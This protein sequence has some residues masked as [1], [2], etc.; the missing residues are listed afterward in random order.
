MA[1]PTISAERMAVRT[2]NPPLAF[3]ASLHLFLGTLGTAKQ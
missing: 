2:T 3:P 1:A